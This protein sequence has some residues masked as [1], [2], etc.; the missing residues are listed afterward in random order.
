M[1]ATMTEVASTERS[2][3]PTRMTPLERETLSIPEAAARLGC[4]KTAAYQLARS[5]RF[6]VPIIK[7]GRKLVVSRY[8]VDRLLGAD[9]TPS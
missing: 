8:A 3:D 6:P 4:G 1:A 7:V 2:G 9:G 5:G